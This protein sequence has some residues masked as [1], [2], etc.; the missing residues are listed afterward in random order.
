MQRPADSSVATTFPV[1][2]SLRAFAAIAVLATHA[3]FWAGDYS[4]PVWGWALARLDVGVAIFFVLSG[5]LL[6]L[7]WFERHRLG[8]PAPSTGRYLWKRLLRLA[9]VYV[10]TAVG[11]LVLLPGNDD[12]GPGDWVTTLLLADIY[13][14]DQLP[15]GLT[16]IWSLA[17]EVAFYL[18]LPVVMWLVLSRRSRGGAD[19]FVVVALGMIITTVVWLLDLSVRLD[20]GD[21]MIRLWLP[22]YL[23]WFTVGLV[24]ARTV[25]RMRR[26][27][28]PRDRLT[29]LV[30]ELGRS[31]GLCW[32]SAAALFAVAATPVAG[33]PD[34]TPPTLGAALTKN[35]LYAAIAGLVVLPGVLAPA[36]GLFA[37]VLSRPALRHLGYL[38]YGIFCVHLVLLELITDW[39]DMPLFAGRGVELFGLTLLTSVLVAEILYRAVERPSRRWRNLRAPWCAPETT[40]APSDTA[41]RSW[42]ATSAPAQPSAAPSGR[43]Q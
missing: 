28:G 32:I 9:P 20:N 34:L 1:L 2:D 18:A 35:L 14:D 41:T 6:S 33:P 40:Q 3:A 39:R 24:L 26:D 38:S 30:A 27:S 25:S 4:E 16:Q 43:H 10:I 5:F 17:T 23:T 15:D 8:L 19:R 29:D 37:R 11:A 21:T 42:G 12:A 7:P 13:V 31:P 36:E 22:S